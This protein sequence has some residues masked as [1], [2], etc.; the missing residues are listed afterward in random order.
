VRQFGA[1]PELHITVVREPDIVPAMLTSNICALAGIA[2]Q[3]MA[4]SPKIADFNINIPHDTEADR[5][6][7]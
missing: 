3:N 2:A 1:L 7:R 6:I 4:S 5:T